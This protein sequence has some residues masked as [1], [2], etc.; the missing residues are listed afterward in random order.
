MKMKK[1][2]YL[3]L[4]LFLAFLTETY[5]QGLKFGL[6][7]GANFSNFQVS[8]ANLNSESITNYHAGVFMD[9]GLSERVSIQPEILYSTIGAKVSL[10]SAVDEFSNKLGYISIPL[11]TKIYLIPDR[12]S[13]DIGPQVSFLLNEKEN[14]NLGKS[15][16]YDFSISGGISLRVLGPIFVQGRYNLGI[17]EIKPNADVTNRVFQLSVGLRF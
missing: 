6:K 1:S 13:I 10:S 14:V 16:S 17:N 12:L 11:L 5:A 2:V 4:F 3:S 7:G 9:I 15:S 8:N